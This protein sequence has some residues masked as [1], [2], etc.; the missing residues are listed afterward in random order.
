MMLEEGSSFGQGN[1]VCFRNE[2][3]FPLFLILFV[4]F[5]SSKVSVY[6]HK[7]SWQTLMLSPTFLDQHDGLIKFPQGH[8]GS[9]KSYKQAFPEVLR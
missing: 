3:L 4:P 5:T 1:V 8:S 9:K 2:E 7:Q 6:G